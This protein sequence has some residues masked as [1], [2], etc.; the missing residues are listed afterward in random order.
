MNIG[1]CYNETIKGEFIFSPLFEMIASMHVISNPEHHLDRMRWMET[2]S[3]KTSA[4]LIEEIRDLKC[5]TN[6]WLIIMDFA[7]ISPYMELSI[8]DAL[9]ELETANLY[10]WNK[11]FKLYSKSIDKNQKT[12]I[13]KVMKAYYQMVFINEINFLQPF[14]SRV[15]KKEI[16]ACMK[17]GLLNRINK[18]HER[19]KFDGKEIIFYKNKEHH[20][21]I[22]ELSKIVITASSFM[23]P[24][25][26]MYEEKG[27]L[28]LTML[29]EVE[30]KKEK[31]P[32]D[33][34]NLFKALGD[35]TRLKIL[36]EIRKKPDTTQ[37]LAIKLRLTEAGISKHLKLLNNAGIIE[38]KR[39]GNYI[40]YN[41][42]NDAIDYM[43]YRL[44]EFIMRS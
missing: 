20:F 43:P 9:T 27:I 23:S 31:V 35:E 16:T 8:L 24:H 41:M 22:N 32:A 12:H 2:L 28:Y 40:F 10:K 15:I 17:E 7:V 19:I 14:L 39:Q 29:V 36:C 1:F 5:L 37:G 25:L 44:Y 3:E 34:V 33:L 38:K 21:S 13:V 42:V 6:E 4:K 18:F 30:E 26:L 11:T